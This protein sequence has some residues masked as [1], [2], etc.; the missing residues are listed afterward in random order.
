MDRMKTINDL[1]FNIL[2]QERD[3]NTVASSYATYKALPKE[4]FGGVPLY[5][6][7]DKAA[8]IAFDE[9]DVEAFVI[10]H[11]SITK[12]FISRFQNIWNTAS[13]I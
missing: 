4:H 11:K 10:S 9:D 8:F 7:K 3:E 13:E 6:Y 12:Y 2:I 1:S 5:I